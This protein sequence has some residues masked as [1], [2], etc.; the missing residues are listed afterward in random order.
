MKKALFHSILIGYSYNME[1]VEVTT[2]RA[3]RWWG[4]D[5]Y[6]HPTNGK[7]R[8]WRGNRLYGKFDNKLDAVEWLTELTALRA[9]YQVAIDEADRAMTDAVNARNVAMQAM[10]RKDEI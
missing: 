8:D 9:K 10:L 5:K 4:R 3:G 2:M 7:L 6:G 1:V